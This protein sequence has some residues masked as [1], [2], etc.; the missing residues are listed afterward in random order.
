MIDFPAGDAKRAQDFIVTTLVGPDSDL[1]PVTLKFLDLNKNGRPDMII[2][3]GGI[4]SVLVN[5]RGSPPTP[6]EHQQISNKLQS[7]RQSMN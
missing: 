5:D 3:V 2:D 4:Q 6:A 7:E 1:D